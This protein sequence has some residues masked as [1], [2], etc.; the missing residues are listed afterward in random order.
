MAGALTFLKTLGK[1][2]GIDPIVLAEMTAPVVPTVSDVSDLAEDLEFVEQLPN[3]AELPI[4]YGLQLPPALATGRPTTQERERWIQVFERLMGRGVLR[5]YHMSQITGVNW[6]RCAIWMDEIREKWGMSQTSVERMRR[7]H[8][9]HQE[10]EEI[11]RIALESAL[12]TKD[13][14]ARSTLLKVALQAGERRA[15]LAGFDRKT[16]EHHHT[17]KVEK[18]TTLAL[19]TELQLPAGALA[20]I[21]QAAAVQLTHAARARIVE[22]DVVDAE[23][24]EVQAPE[25]GAPPEA[26]SPAAP[27]RPKPKGASSGGGSSPNSRR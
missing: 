12:A 24:A 5:P 10:A 1:K 18:R 14:K 21:G 7:V 8:D 20:Q 15:A 16:I 4:M 3:A 13:P 9:L 22:A 2:R 17:G 19:E 27:A 6:R 23:F 25:S 26:A 11:A